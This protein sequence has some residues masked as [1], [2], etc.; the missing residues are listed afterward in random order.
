M[1]KELNHQIEQGKIVLARDRGFNK[2][3]IFVINQFVP[4]FDKDAGG[5]CSFIYLNI[6]LWTRI[7]I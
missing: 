1:E 2:R 7:K 4:I 5:S 6:F 3:K